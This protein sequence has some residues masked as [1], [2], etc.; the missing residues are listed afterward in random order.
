MRVAALFAGTLG[1]ISVGVLAIMVTP[2]RG[3]Q[4]LAVEHE[5]SFVTPSQIVPV[6]SALLER[7]AGQVAAE[8]AGALGV[9]RPSTDVSTT[10]AV[11]SGKVTVAEQ[12]LEPPAPL[13]T[14]LDS[15][16]AIV[17]ARSLEGHAAGDP[18][19][20][21]LA[22][23]RTIQAEVLATLGFAT[24]VTLESLLTG[25]QALPVSAV[26]DDDESLVTLLVGSPMS[27]RLDELE[28]TAAPEGTPVLDAAGRLIG[29]CTQ[30]P[31]GT[32]D[33]I[34]ALDVATGVTTTTVPVTTLVATTVV[35]TSTS[36]PTST[37]STTST[38]STTSTSSTTT[39]TTS[40]TVP[41]ATTR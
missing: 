29:L 38:T 2:G 28:F 15:G 9:S 34:P 33:L 22:S 8:V 21:R 19:D 23:G 13:A 17:T 7:T 36:V 39:S 25:E 31:D 30:A 1:L 14:L 5:P 27:V 32:T 37:S 3:N 6:T 35:I 26:P 11:V 18:V 20:V 41:A 16:L 24:V 40:T 12:E 4:P 10:I